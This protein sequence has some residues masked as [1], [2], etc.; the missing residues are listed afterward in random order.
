MDEAT[1]VELLTT[2]LAESDTEID[3]GG[4]APYPEA[5]EIGVASFRDAGVI[6]DNEGLILS[7]PDGSEFQITIV[8][9][10]RATE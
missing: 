10:L 3:T 8:Q 2:V 5:N 1:L 6:T 7:M 4:D 9:V